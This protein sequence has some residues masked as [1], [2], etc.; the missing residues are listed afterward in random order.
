MQINKTTLKFKLRFDLN[1]NNG[2]IVFTLKTFI[3][4]YNFKLI[5]SYK[6]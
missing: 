3:K 1:L 5:L 6:N 2:L 4:N